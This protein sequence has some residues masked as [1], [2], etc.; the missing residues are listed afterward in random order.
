MT[1]MSDIAKLSMASAASQAS[2][3]PSGSGAPKNM[4]MSSGNMFVLKTMMQ[5]HD[6]DEDD[7]S[8]STSSEETSEE[9]SD[10]DEDDLAAAIKRGSRNSVGQMDSEKAAKSAVDLEAGKKSYGITALM[11]AQEAQTMSA[12]ER[13]MK[14][15]ETGGADA[16]MDPSMQAVKNAK[17]IQHLIQETCDEQ[18]KCHERW[19]RRR[20]AGPPPRQETH[21]LSQHSTVGDRERMRQKGRHRN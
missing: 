3:N 6:S 5:A 10:S 8:I 1:M 2:S 11:S 7:D 12:S 16:I 17:N 20:A 4:G 14:K 13:A 18:A 19:L 9:E 15:G 21:R